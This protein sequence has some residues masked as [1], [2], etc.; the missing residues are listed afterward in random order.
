[1]H[2][3]SNALGEPRCLWN[4][5]QLKTGFGSMRPE[6]VR[7]LI[8]SLTHSR[9]HHCPCWKTLLH[10]TASRVGE[11]DHDHA[12]LLLRKLKLEI[13]T[14][15]CN[16]LPHAATHPTHPEAAECRTEGRH[17]Q[18]NTMPYTATHSNTLQHTQDAMGRAEGRYSQ[19]NPVQP[20]A[21]HCNTLQ[22]TLRMLRAALKIQIL[23]AIYYNTFQC[24]N[25]AIE[26]CNATIQHCNTI[27]QHN[28]VTQHCSTLWG[29]RGQSWWEKFLMQYPVTHCNTL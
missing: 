25:T 4:D 20:S 21:T 10:H 22:H 17:S 28:T 29:C 5:L 6:A 16:A 8:A 12:P 14:T 15:H 1:M 27:P 11:W 19:C 23:T 9:N 7:F 13:N 26:P 24:N 3:F 2:W 18:C